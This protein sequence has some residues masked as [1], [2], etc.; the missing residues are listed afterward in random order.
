[1][2]DRVF[3]ELVLALADADPRRAPADA[4]WRGEV[5]QAA[6]ILLFRFLFILYA[7]DRGLLP[8]DNDR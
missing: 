5:K 3:P 4:I 7:E 1:M 8:L 2:F 6:L